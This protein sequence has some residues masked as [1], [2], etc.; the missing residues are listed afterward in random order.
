VG[1]VRIVPSLSHQRAR[2]SVRRSGDAKECKGKFAHYRVHRRIVLRLPI[3]GTAPMIAVV[4]PSMAADLL[5]QSRAA[6]SS[7]ET[8]QPTRMQPGQR[9]QTGMTMDGQLMQDRRQGTGIGMTMERSVRG[10]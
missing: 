8:A 3:I 7:S 1:F 4:T 6:S 10:G 9:P 2:C 5:H